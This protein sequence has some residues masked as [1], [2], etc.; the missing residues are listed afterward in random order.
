MISRDVS[1]ICAILL[2]LI[3]SLLAFIDAGR[4]PIHRRPFRVFQACVC[5]Y[6]VIAYGF[7]LAYNLGVIFPAELVG[8]LRTGMFT[9]WGVIL[10]II[11]IAAEIISYRHRLIHADRDR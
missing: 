1:Y 9:R 4:A 8:Y 2:A 5:F 6:F 7:A 11:A 10:L 3:V